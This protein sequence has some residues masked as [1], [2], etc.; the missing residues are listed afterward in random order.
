MYQPFYSYHSNSD[1]SIKVTEGYIVL[2]SQT[3]YKN[4]ELFGFNNNNFEQQKI[5]YT[6]NGSNYQYIFKGDIYNHRNKSFLKELRSIYQIYDRI[7]QKGQYVDMKFYNIFKQNDQIKILDLGLR[8]YNQNLYI[9]R[10]LKLIL[11][12]FLT[13][14]EYKFIKEL[15]Q[16]QIF[17]QLKQMLNIRDQQDQII[18][19]RIFEQDPTQMKWDE[20]N[21]ILEQ[22]KYQTI[23]RIKQ[24]KSFSPYGYAMQKIQN[25]IRSQSG[26]N[27][28]NTLN[29]SRNENSFSMQSANNTISIQQGTR[30]QH[31][32]SSHSNSNYKKFNRA[33]TILKSPHKRNNLK[34]SNSFTIN[35]L[36]KVQTKLLDNESFS[37][38][39][40]NL[41]THQTKSTSP[42]FNGKDS[43]KSSQI[44][45][46]PPTQRAILNQTLED[47]LNNQINSMGNEQPY[48]QKK[49]SNRKNLLRTYI[50]SHVVKIDNDIETIYLKEEKN[51]HQDLFNKHSQKY[52]NLYKLLNF[53]EKTLQQTINELDALN[54]LWFM[55]LFI[56]QKRI[57]QIRMWVY[58]DIK[59]NI[60]ELEFFDEF[61]KSDIYQKLIENIKCENENGLQQIQQNLKITLWKSEKLDIK[62]KQKILPFLN[63]NIS[64]DMSQIAFIYYSGQIIHK[65]IQLYKENNQKIKLA[66]K[67]ICSLQIMDKCGIS[68]KIN[69]RI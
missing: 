2:E 48:I 33:G 22:Q 6:I 63:E 11:K 60:W 31:S 36:N 47:C 29:V 26:R 24:I 44:V 46:K 30:D 42:R 54:N 34:T 16:D 66:I 45:S 28:R 4:I 9:S 8:V 21:N 68:Q 27:V 18:L 19:Q 5:D 20:L 12:L 52:I 13:K 57:Y 39:I 61:L 59:E 35:D 7:I 51:I 65:I 53:V 37:Q 40:Q 58:E 64:K 55:P 43:M 1:Y 41:E 38:T 15:K 14:S 3:N 62:S 23:D 67:S 50:P 32:I 25:N 49:A 10:L 69:L 56:I 17:P